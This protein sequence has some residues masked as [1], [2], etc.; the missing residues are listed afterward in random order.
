MGY[1]PTTGCEISSTEFTD[2]EKD[3]IKTVMD[4][5]A[6]QN[7]VAGAI[8]GVNTAI[9]GVQG[10]LNG[11]AF[12]SIFAGLSSAISTLSGQVS[13]YK[14]HSD[15]VSGVNLDSLG[16]NDEPSLLGLYGIASAFNSAQ[17]SMIGGV[18][19]NFSDVFGSILGPANSAIKSAT[20]TL[21]NGI[22]NFIQQHSGVSS[23]SY[24]GGFTDA[25]S[26]FTTK[27]SGSSSN[28]GTLISGDNTKY[29]NAL[30]YVKKF[31]LGNVVLG[32]QSDPCFGGNLIKGVVVNSNV[33]QKL[34]ALPKSPAMV[35]FEALSATALE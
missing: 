22:Y 3:I 4:G 33:R 8:G 35:D 32:S 15:R 1:F 6:F 18:V 24:P 14:T 27:M 17:E 20:D 30:G 25:L 21:E 12:P 16:P 19:D 29:S 11:V 26:N 23:G 9:S 10:L 2:G 5:N 31:S 7:P 34:D 13:S 28:I